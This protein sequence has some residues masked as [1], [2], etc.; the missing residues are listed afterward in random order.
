MA[1]RKRCAAF[2]PAR[3]PLSPSPAFTSV[4]SPRRRRG[5]GNSSSS[6]RGSASPD[7]ACSSVVETGRRRGR[8]MS[9]R[10]SLLSG[11]TPSTLE[12]NKAAAS[13]ASPEYREHRTFPPGSEDRC[14]DSSSFSSCR[15]MH[16][17]TATVLD[18][19]SAP[20]HPQATERR[21]LPR[22]QKERGRKQGPGN[23]WSR[24][25]WRRNRRGALERRRTANHHRHRS[26]YSSAAPGVVPPHSLLL[27]SPTQPIRR[28]MTQAIA[29]RNVLEISP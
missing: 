15:P 11:T 25:N 29:A 13:S 5:K 7:E 28:A 12:R 9:A 20:S 14:G 6:C 16:A 27:E 24:Q 21:R 26:A 1:W 18:V 8:T 22:Q 10:P 17:A 3:L 4:S 19:R 23:R 2:S